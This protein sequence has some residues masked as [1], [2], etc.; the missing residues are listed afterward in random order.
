MRDTTLDDEKYNWHNI[1]AGYVDRTCVVV[2]VLCNQ[3]EVLASDLGDNQS[4]Y[5]LLIAKTD[6]FVRTEMPFGADTWVA[7]SSV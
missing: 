5:L 2:T 7:T 6:V 4:H 3:P 1:G